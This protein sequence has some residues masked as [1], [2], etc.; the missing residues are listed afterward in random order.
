MR[1]ILAASILFTLNAAGAAHGPGEP[2]VPVGIVYDTPGALD[3]REDL[4]Y[5]RKLGFSVV[6]RRDPASPREL[7][8]ERLASLLARGL[9]APPDPIDAGGLDIMSVHEHSSGADVRQRAWIAIGRGLRGVLFDGWRSLRGNPAALAEAASFADNVTRNA[10]LFAPLSASARPIRIEAASPD[11]FAR[12]V[13]SPEAMVL[14]AANLTSA[15][16]RVTL[17]F[18]PD[19][20]E[21]IWQNME[22]GAAVNFVAGPEGPFYTRTFAPL[23]VAV[24]MIRKRTP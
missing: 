18:A 7:R 22:S 21:A 3:F 5:F 11:L 12:F 10:A 17:R 16:Q 13:E 9:A 19:V 20:P 15:E 1:V 23:D 2:F 8:V 14:V 24:L 6:A 4:V